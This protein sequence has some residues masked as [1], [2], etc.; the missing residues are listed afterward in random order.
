MREITRRR[1]GELDG[2]DERALR[3]LTAALAA[4]S[5][6][7]QVRIIAPITW[8]SCT[9]PPVR[10]PWS[11][12]STMR[13]RRRRGKVR[14]LTLLT[15]ILLRAR[16]KLL[17]RRSLVSMLYP[18]SLRAPTN[19]ISASAMTIFS[20]NGGE[21]R[22]LVIVADHIRP[23]GVPTTAASCHP[24]ARCGHASIVKSKATNLATCQS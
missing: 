22:P 21:Q 7:Q 20:E 12:T 6:G 24:A 13:W 3:A 9:L 16:A 18:P 5:A 4:E 19:R 11:I 23:G 8:G 15:C 14:V 10:G 1:P 17:H 2:G